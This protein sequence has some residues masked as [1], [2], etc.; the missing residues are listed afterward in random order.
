MESSYFQVPVQL[1][2]RFDS[3]FLEQ[4]N[5]LI[6]GGGVVECATSQGPEK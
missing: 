3:L 2:S 4:N 5:G 6:G 1:S